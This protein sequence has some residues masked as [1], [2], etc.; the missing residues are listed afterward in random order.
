MHCTRCKNGIAETDKRLC[1]RCAKQ[2]RKSTKKTMRLRK[3][4]GICRDCGIDKAL[5]GKRCFRCYQTI[6]LF[7]WQYKYS[8]IVESKEFEMICQSENEK[9]QK[10]LWRALRLVRPSQRNISFGTKHGREKYPDEEVIENVVSSWR[11]AVKLLR[12]AAKNV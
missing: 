8:E 3:R 4:K 6:S 2:K 7:R 10:I 5:P 11:Q 9:V 1:K 12:R